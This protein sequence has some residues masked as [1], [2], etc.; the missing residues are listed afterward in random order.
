MDFRQ[1]KQL[2]VVFSHEKTPVENVREKLIVRHMSLLHH[3]G[4]PTCD[5]TVGSY[6]RE[7]VRNSGLPTRNSRVEPVTECCFCSRSMRT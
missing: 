2:G 1:A 5:L 7:S 3:T 4:M 6:G